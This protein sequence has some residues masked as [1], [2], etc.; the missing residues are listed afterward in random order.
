MKHSNTL[1]HSLS[2]PSI[3][4][5]VPYNLQGVIKKLAWAKNKKKINKITTSKQLPT[6]YVYVE[7]SKSDWK[8]PCKQVLP[9]RLTYTIK[10]SFK[11]FKLLCSM[12]LQGINSKDLI[13]LNEITSSWAW[14]DVS[15]PTHAYSP[16]LSISVFRTQF[17]MMQRVELT[18]FVFVSD[19][20]F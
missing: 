1:T 12:F 10:Q 15:R 2:N 14:P 13:R 20:S 3:P 6:C 11:Y 18:I 4:N 19:V 7:N 5:H 17:R 16:C 8:I 9:K